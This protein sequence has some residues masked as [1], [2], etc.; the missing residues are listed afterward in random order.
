MGWNEGFA[1]IGWKVTNEVEV[2][3]KRDFTV[4][5]KSVGIILNNKTKYFVYPNN[6]KL[7]II[8]ET[9]IIKGFQSHFYHQKL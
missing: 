4:V 6:Y 9:W 5:L 1:L 8:C 7:F 2:N 3:M